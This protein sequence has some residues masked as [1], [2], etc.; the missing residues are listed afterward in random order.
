MLTVKIANGDGSEFIC[1]ARIVTTGVE[2]SEADTPKKLFIHYPDGDVL[3]VR[4]GDGRGGAAYV[5][6]RF[7]ATISKYQL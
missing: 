3:D 4:L 6:N 5:M 7:G 1:E 2:L